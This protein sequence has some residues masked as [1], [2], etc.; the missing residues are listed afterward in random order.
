MQANL[1]TCEKAIAPVGQRR[2]RGGVTQTRAERVRCALLQRAGSSGEREC[3]ALPRA[4]RLYQ[5]M[6]SY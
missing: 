4:D 5:C 1:A 2:H 6:P 3:P